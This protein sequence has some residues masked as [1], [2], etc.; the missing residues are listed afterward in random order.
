M[1]AGIVKG[2]IVTLKTA[3]LEKNVTLQYPFEKKERLYRGLHELNKDACIACGLCAINCPVNAIKI[4]Q[5][6]GHEK[7]R[8]IEDYDYEVNIGNC[9][10]CGF[11][12]DVCPK[13]AIK[14]TSQY[15]MA[16][17]NSR[18]LIKNLVETKNKNKNEENREQKS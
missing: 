5:K 12:E 18:N 11:C 8:K 16:D 15:E 4:K 1:I 3:F 10:W 9:I 13:K 14:L 2:L 17:Y 7:T 6:P